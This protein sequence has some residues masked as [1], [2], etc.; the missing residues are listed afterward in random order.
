MN[1]YTIINYDKNY[2]YGVYKIT[3][4]INGK[5]YIG[6]S[7]NIRARI[8]QH[9]N[10]EVNVHLKNSFD[11]YG[12]KNFQFEVIK[13]TKDLDYWE[14]FFIYWYRSTD[15]KYGYNIEDVK[16][17]DILEEVGLWQYSIIKHFDD[18]HESAGWLHSR[19]IKLSFPLPP[20]DTL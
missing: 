12:I 19:K 11:K 13:V 14:K 7:I 18:L 20:I 16:S 1:N 5:V 17:I 6:Q 9:V 8:W 15:S 10:Y 3:N 2:R 4:T